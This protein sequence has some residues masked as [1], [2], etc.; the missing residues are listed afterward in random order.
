MEIYSS[1]RTLCL[2]DEVDGFR[3]DEYSRPIATNLRNSMQRLLTFVHDV[4]PFAIFLPD[5]NNEENQATFLL[6]RYRENYQHQHGLAVV[7][8]KITDNKKYI[9]CSSS[10]GE[11]SF[12]E[13]EL[14][15]NIESQESEYIFYQRTFSDG[16]SSLRFESSV[17]KN[18]YLAYEETESFQKLIL[19]HCPPGDLD[20][21]ISMDI[22]ILPF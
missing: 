18:F 14:P 3:L 15:K 4:E 5:E 7:I 13:R 16:S 17:K 12:K 21:T 1:C 9:M 19:K 2:G 8:S 22:S 20:E 10:N 6:H 11:V